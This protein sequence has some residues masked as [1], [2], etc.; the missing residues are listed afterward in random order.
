MTRRPGSP[1]GEALSS[2]CCRPGRASVV[3]TAVSRARSS[4]PASPE[5][6]WR[7]GVRRPSS[8]WR[9]P[10]GGDRERAGSLARG[11]LQAE[12]LPLAEDVSSRCPI[13][14]IRGEWLLLGGGRDDRVSLRPV[15]ERL[16]GHLH[17]RV[18][19]RRNEATAGA[20]Q[21][22]GPAD[23]T[24]RMADVPA[25]AHVDQPDQ[26]TAFPAA[27]APAGTVSREVT[28][29]PPAAQAPRKGGSRARMRA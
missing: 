5:G 18:G 29:R 9:G 28:P 6:R 3:W 14:E 23:F 10:V 1:S 11:C 8:G 19:L 17:R 27:G 4:R 21:V 22:G 15:V 25:S 12:V 13:Q 26:D 2:D 24:V 7:H 20:S 16:C